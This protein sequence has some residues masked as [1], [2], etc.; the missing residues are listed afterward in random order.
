MSQT[1]DLDQLDRDIIDLLHNDGRAS[2][3]SLGRKLD[4]SEAAIRK[5]I[6]RLERTGLISYGLLIDVGA[7][8]MEVFGWMYV[9]V[10][11]TRVKDA[12]HAIVA[13]PRCSGAALKTGAYNL[14]AHMYAKD[15]R[16]MLDLV[17]SIYELPG[18]DRVMFRQVNRYPLHRHE[19]VVGTDDEGFQSWHGN[20]PLS[21]QP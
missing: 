3:R 6:K 9:K 5:R 13:M 10:R 7:T 15:Q 4:V 17:E 18:V 14:L 20:P 2:N 1:Y 11:P 12:F 21:G 16:S 8:G 19:Y